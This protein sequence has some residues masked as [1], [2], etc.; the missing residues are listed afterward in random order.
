MTDKLTCPPDPP[1]CVHGVPY[2]PTGGMS[3]RCARCPNGKPV[4]R[5]KTTIEASMEL[6]RNLR[7]LGRE[8]EKALPYWLRPT[9]ILEFIDDIIN[10]KLP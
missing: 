9:V 4:P 8:C 1:A 7:K 10:R 3:P 2:Y 6:K 5:P